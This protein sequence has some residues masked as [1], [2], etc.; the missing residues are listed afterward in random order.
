MLDW[1]RR[2]SAQSE[3][4]L[5]PKDFDPAYWKSYIAREGGPVLP[6]RELYISERCFRGCSYC[7]NVSLP[8]GAMMPFELI[9]TAFATSSLV[10]Y[11]PIFLGDGEVLIYEDKDSG[12]SLLDVLKF[13]LC[14]LKLQVE[15]TTAGLLPVNRKLGTPVLRA[16]GELGEDAL[17]RLK[18]FVSFNESHGMGPKE[19]FACMEETFGLIRNV[20]SVKAQ[21]RAAPHRIQEEQE[22]LGII[23][24]SYRAKFG[25][26][27][28]ISNSVL[29]TDAGRLSPSQVIP[30]KP[31]WLDRFFPANH[32]SCRIM[33]SKDRPVFGLRPDG[34]LDAWCG[35][36]G[37]RGCDLGNIHGH[38]ALQIFRAYRAFIGEFGKRL[39]STPT[40]L[41]NCEWHRRWNKS[42]ALPPSKSPILNRGE[43]LVVC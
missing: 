8:T 35:A 41:D 32:F 40:T 19:Y 26:P 9:T 42:F 28:I 25:V 12:K 29:M 27:H 37:S 24:E 15:F 13:L 7:A 38:D 22:R 31:I 43:R 39:N 21:L 1:F 2:S 23:L 14:D 6:I 16:L 33:H 4:Q 36:F 3:F 30:T 18:I 34:R 11:K 17:S 5:N 20:R 10:P